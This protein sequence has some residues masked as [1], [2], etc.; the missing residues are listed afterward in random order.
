MKEITIVTAFLDIG[1]GKFKNTPFVRTN[2]QY[3][4]YFKFWARMKNK[5]IVYTDSENEKR[6]KDI[7]QEFGLANKTIVIVIDNVYDIEYSIYQHMLKVSENTQFKNFRYFPNA[8][9][10]RANYDYIMLMKYW[11]MNNAVEKNLA[12]GMVAWID[13]GFN[14]GGK[15]YVKP[16]EFDFEWKYNFDT[17]IHLFSLQELDSVSGVLSLQFLFDSIMGCLLICPSE[18][19][20]DLWILVRDAMNG[21]LMLDCIDDDQQLLLMAYKKRPNLFKV[22]ISDWFMPLKEYGGEHLTIKNTT[23]KK[24]QTP[25]F[26][27]RL[28]DKIVNILGKRKVNTRKAFAERMYNIATKYYKED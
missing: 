2:E 23:P 28:Y 1:R 3:F 26:N 17:K 6:I 24:S 22:H 10:N 18:Y 7:R 4:N 13:F 27:K 16:E 21:L 25:S 14:H 15:C 9:S 12:N 11:C 20:Q 19:C 8:M 5:L